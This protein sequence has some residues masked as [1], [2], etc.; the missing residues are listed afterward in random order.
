[1][2]DSKKKRNSFRPSVQK[3]V[4]KLMDLGLSKEDIASHVKMSAY[5]VRSWA[6]R[7]IRPHPFIAEKLDRL[8]S[9]TE[10]KNK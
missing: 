4:L 5:A 7:D 2:V 1:M 3:V 6:L 10:K 9:Q 8:L